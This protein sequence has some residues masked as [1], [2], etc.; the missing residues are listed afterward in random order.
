MVIRERI[1]K[2]ALE[3]GFN[4]FEI[5]GL[6]KF[7]TNIFDSS[8]S[9]FSKYFILILGA[10]LFA[11]MLVVLPGSPAQAAKND[12]S[13]A[14]EETCTPPN[15]WAQTTRVKNPEKPTKQWTFT[16][17]N[18]EMLVSLTFFYYQDYSIP[19]CP[20]DCSQ[21]DCQTDE[22]GNGTTPLGDF[23]VVDGKLGAN[24]GSKRFEGRLPQGTYQ[25]SFTANGNP[26][27]LNVGLNVRQSTVPTATLFPTNTPLPTTPP[28]TAT[29]PPTVT[30]TE[31]AR[32]QPP[33]KNPTPSPTPRPGRT[34]P[35]TLPPP[36]PFPGSPAPQVLIPQT[37][38]VPGANALVLLPLGIGLI[39]LGIAFYGITKRL[40][41]K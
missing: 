7:M 15:D 34:P 26:G 40:K 33:A 17:D 32:T 41:A 3:V 39:G 25:V 2:P 14:Q 22:T 23:T 28:P 18:P 11:G 30:P 8:K 5:N 13:S 20:Y 9:L 27:S 24:R 1:A 21:G 12:L 19:G 16:V 6:G 29:L 37:G 36:T 10:C 4:F 31:P 38:L 35:A